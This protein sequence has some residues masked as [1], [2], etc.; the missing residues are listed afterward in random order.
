MYYYWVAVFFWIDFLIVVKSSQDSD[1]QTFVL[2]VGV[3]SYQDFYQLK[4][5]YM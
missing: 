4:K 1:L 5:D 2:I 3:I